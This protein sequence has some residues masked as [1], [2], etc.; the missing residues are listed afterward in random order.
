MGAEFL[1]G[2]WRRVTLV[3]MSQSVASYIISFRSFSEEQSID[4]SKMFP[5]NF[6]NSLF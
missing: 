1:G 5:L 6:P 2:T 3:F 4:E